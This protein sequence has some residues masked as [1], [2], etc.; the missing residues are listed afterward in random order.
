MSVLQTHIER[1]TT[2]AAR[3]LSAEGRRV[4]HQSVNR[5][6]NWAEGYCQGD[7]GCLRSQYYNYLE[8]IPNSVYRVGRWTVYNTGVYALE[9]ADEDLQGMDPD[10]AF[11]WDL[12]LTWPRVDAAS[13]PG[14]GL[15][16]ADAAYSALRARVHQLMADWIKGGWNLVLDVHL[17]GLDDCYVSASIITS[18]YAGGAHN[19]EDFSTFNWNVRAKRA[20]Q[21]ADL[22]R[23]DSDWKSAILA[24]YRQRL[25]ESGTDLSEW[26]LSSDGMDTL[27]TNGFVTTASG[28]RFVQ[29]Q[30]ATRN[31]NV[32]AVDLSWNDLAPW[33]VPEASCSISPAEARIRAR[34]AA[35]SPAL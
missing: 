11:T 29:H 6:L 28:L 8:A 3:R 13:N 20:L 22:F 14:Q 1:Q 16:L 27:F 32:P 12:Q 34:G 5:F 30:G 24:L 2:K 25:Q 23:V 7:A 9:W 31:E 19:Y 15:A 21:N 10:R 4:M 33:L 26:A 18:T 17:E 35:W